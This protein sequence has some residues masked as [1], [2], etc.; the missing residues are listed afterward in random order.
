MNLTPSH[1]LT[2][3]LRTELMQWAPFG[4]M[5]P[6]HVERFLLAA[7]QVYFEPNEVVLSLVSGTVTHR[8]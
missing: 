2:N 7:T 1:S 3:N 4:Q 5:A 8:R 6:E